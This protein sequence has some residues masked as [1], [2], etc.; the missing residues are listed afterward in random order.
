MRQLLFILFFLATPLCVYADWG[1]F[2]GAELVQRCQNAF[3]LGKDK[4]EKEQFIFD[5]GVCIGYLH[6]I[7]LMLNRTDINYPPEFPKS[8]I[9][10]G[11]V[12]TDLVNAIYT[13]ADATPNLLKFDA[14]TI[15]VVAWSKRFPCGIK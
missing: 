12:Q 6:G 4:T 8:C 15:V 11:T 14:I 2:T 9:P 7:K 10:K 1:S 13:Q 5:Q 3:K